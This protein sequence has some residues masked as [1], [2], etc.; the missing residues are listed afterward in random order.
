ML[1]EKLKKSLAKKNN[2]HKLQL[3]T[4]CRS[5]SIVSYLIRSIEEK[6]KTLECPVCLEVV[7][8]PPMYRCQ[9]EHLIC[10]S[11]RAK[12]GECPECRERYS[13]DPVRHRFAEK[14]ALELHRLK[15]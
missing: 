10:S 6:E 13:G 14:M 7:E 4:E 8:E 3:G 15:K 12:I 9:Q 2:E 1:T 11:C 5:E